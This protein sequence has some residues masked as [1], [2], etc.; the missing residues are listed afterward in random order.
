MEDVA[1]IEFLFTYISQKLMN[2]IK[3]IWE[4]YSW[5]RENVINEN[6]IFQNTAREASM[7][8]RKKISADR[9]LLVFGLIKEHAF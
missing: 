7:N 6:R 2:G 1:R 5:E 4:Q 3:I 8:P 9:W